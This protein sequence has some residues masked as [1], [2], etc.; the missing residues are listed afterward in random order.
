VHCLP[1]RTMNIASSR[2]GDDFSSNVTLPPLTEDP[3]WIHYPPEKTKNRR[4]IEGQLDEFGAELM[5]LWLTKKETGEESYRQAKM[6]F[7]GADECNSHLF[8]SYGTKHISS[9]R[10]SKDFKAKFLTFTGLEVNLHMARHLAAKIILDTDPG[11]IGFVSVLLGHADEKIT[12]QFYAELN[13]VI[14]Q[15]HWL[16]ILVEEHIR[17]RNQFPIIRWSE[18]GLQ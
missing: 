2:I 9:D 16:K 14:I 8:P 3:C 10:L 17:I 12:R 5:R 7:V 6:R 13:S 11:M 4:R 18:K 15:R 1:A